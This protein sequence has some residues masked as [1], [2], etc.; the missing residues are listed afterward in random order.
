MNTLTFIAQKSSNMKTTRHSILPFLTDSSMVLGMQLLLHVSADGSVRTLKKKQLF[1]SSRRL[2][3]TCQRTIQGEV[4]LALLNLFLLG[5]FGNLGIVQAQTSSL[6]SQPESKL[7]PLLLQDIEEN[8]FSPEALK[9]LQLGDTS[10]YSPK[11]KKGYTVGHVLRDGKI[12]ALRLYVAAERNGIT[13]PSSDYESV[14]SAAGA[15]FGNL[16]RHCGVGTDRGKSSFFVTRDCGAPQLENIGKFIDGNVA[17]RFVQMVSGPR[18]WKISDISGRAVDIHTVIGPI[19]RSGN[20]VRHSGHPFG[21]TNLE[22]LVTRELEIYISSDGTNKV[23]AYY[24]WYKD[25]SHNGVIEVGVVDFALVGDVLNEIPVL[26]GFV[27]TELAL[28]AQSAMPHLYRQEDIILKLFTGKDFGLDRSDF[29]AW[30][31]DNSKAFL[32]NLKND[33]SK[34]RRHDRGA[35]RDRR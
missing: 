26:Q 18:Q 30:W 16:H 11:N 22:V 25:R 23:L 33:P 10:V 17:R 32:R 3:T 27:E 19:Q 12:A 21:V 4:G 14:Q 8:Q 28:V 34:G 15:S 35:K 31:K 6:L 24:C 29:Q 13:R 7:V 1:I 5:L 2:P 20:W 9:F